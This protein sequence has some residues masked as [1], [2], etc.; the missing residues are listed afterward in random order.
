MGQ[1]LG[2]NND[3]DQAEEV[4]VCIPLKCSS[5]QYAWGKIGGESLVAQLISEEVKK[6]EPYAEL[7]MGTH[8]KAPAKTMD[9]KLLSEEINQDLPYLFKVLSVNKALSIQAHPT[10]SL[11]EKLHAER[12]D[13]YKDP[14]HKPEMTIALTPFEAMCGFR[15]STEIASHMKTYPEISNLIGEDLVAAFVKSAEENEEGAVKSALKDAFSAVMKAEKEKVAEQVQ[16]L[17]KSLADKELPDDDPTKGEMN[18]EKLILRLQ[19]QFPDDVGVFAPLFL[20]LVRLQPGE[21]IF[22]S[23]GLPHA[24]LDGNCLEAMARSDNVVRAGLTPKL[25]DTPVL[26]DMLDYSIAVPN[27]ITPE[28]D[29]G[30]RMY[31]PTDDA[32]QEF[33][34]ATAHLSEGDDV[35]FP[36]VPG[37]SIVL[38]LEGEGA[39]MDTAFKKGDIFCCRGE[40]PVTATSNCFLARCQQRS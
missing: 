28:A 21:A 7:W 35:T 20:N 36:G 12:P 40:I 9:G 1:V 8:H 17:V 3:K 4:G 14:N 32:V 37:F 33:T 19:S 2:C 23:A 38:V 6:D 30:V 31:I 5:Q 29:N 39:M 24:Y 10:K 25:R 15:P 26:C 22:L 34:M 13:V 16:S 18:M 11:A 27:V